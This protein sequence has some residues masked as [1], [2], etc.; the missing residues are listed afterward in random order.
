MKIYLNTLGKKT[1]REWDTYLDLKDK[2]GDL[3]E[4]LELSYA[5]S[6]IDLLLR[7]Y[8]DVDKGIDP[9]AFDKIFVLDRFKEAFDIMRYIRI[10]H[11]D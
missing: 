1:V 7:L 8:P 9:E 11:E 2:F 10:D 3:D 4:K 5:Q 6:I